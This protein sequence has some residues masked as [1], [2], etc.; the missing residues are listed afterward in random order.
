MVSTTFDLTVNNTNDAPVLDPIAQVTT[1]EDGN[2]TSGN[3]TST[4]I[5]TGDTATYSTTAT[6]AGFVL[7]S[8]GSYTFDPTDAAYQSMGKGDTQTLTIPVTVTDTAGDS[9]TQDLVIN[10]TGTNDTPVL[11]SIAARS[12]KEDAP[13]ITGQVTGTDIDTGDSITYSIANPVDGL[14][15]NTDGSWSFDPSHAAYQSLAEGAQQT[16]TVTVTGTDSQG[17]TD[18]RWMKTQPSALACLRAPLRILIRVIH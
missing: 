2:V 14:T 10:L 13:S 15:V 12:V 3:I 18:T 16:L 6:V 8:N 4:D 7:N 17:A 1:V 11:N 9:D 5:D